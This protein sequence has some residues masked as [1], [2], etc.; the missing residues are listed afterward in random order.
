MA[1]TKMGRPPKVN[2]VAQPPVT[3]VRIP[4]DVLAALDAKVAS[5]NERLASTG[6]SLSRTA[7][8]VRLLR[9]AVLPP[10]EGT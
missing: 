2:K 6:A 5:E 7:L 10:R 1:K 8:I 3:G 4:D 9:E